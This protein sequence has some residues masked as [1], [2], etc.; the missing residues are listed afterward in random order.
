MFFQHAPGLYNF[1]PL[2]DGHFILAPPEQAFTQL[3]VN[4]RAFM[5]GITRDE[6]ALTGQFTECVCVCVCF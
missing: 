3:P 5:T 6:G 2:V 4:G 1:S